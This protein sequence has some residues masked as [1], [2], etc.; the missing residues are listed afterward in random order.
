MS[1]AVAHESTLAQTGLRESSELALP[2]APLGLLSVTVSAEGE[3][4][5]VANRV[6]R[7][8]VDL[9][10]SDD[11]EMATQLGLNVP[12]Q[13]LQGDAVT[14]RPISAGADV[15]VRSLGVY[16]TPRG[17]AAL[18]RIRV[19]ENAVLESPGLPF[20]WTEGRLLRRCGF[21]GTLFLLNGQERTVYDFK[22]ET[23]GQHLL[24]DLVSWQ[25]S[26]KLRWNETAISPQG[27][28]AMPERCRTA[29]RYI[30]SDSTSRF[31]EVARQVI[32]LDLFGNT[33]HTVRGFVGIEAAIVT[34]TN[35]T[36]TTDYLPMQ[37]SIATTGAAGDGTV[38]AR[39]ENVHCRSPQDLSA[40]TLPWSEGLT[41]IG[42]IPV[43]SGTPMLIS[44]AHQP[45]GRLSESVVLDEAC[46][47]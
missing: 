4:H 8:L 7:G 6:Y 46:V 13:T 21:D 41:G 39:Y 26:L 3:S 24:P 40:D 29:M 2:P 38:R 10:V 32:V 20:R 25:V 42:R 9:T 34:T 28:V 36:R 37:S 44:T 18:L 5:L 22:R 45:D 43:G 11:N 16:A 47:E 35:N 12:I 14:T 1:A 15:S 17:R 19:A 31:P 27:D 30:V 23:S 33:A